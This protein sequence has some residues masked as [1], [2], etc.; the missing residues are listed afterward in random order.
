MVGPRDDAYDAAA[1]VL[2]AYAGDGAMV[3][4]VRHA[5]KKVADGDEAPLVMLVTSRTSWAS[6]SRSRLRHRGRQDRGWIEVGLFVIELLALAVAVVLTLGAA[7]PAAGGLIAASR[8]VIQQI[9]SG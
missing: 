7:S 5:W 4:G 9:F 8:F 6:W 1:D 2:A 3:D